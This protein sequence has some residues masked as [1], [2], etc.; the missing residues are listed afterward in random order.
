MVPDTSKA[1]PTAKLR[2]VWRANIQ[3]NK[4][5]KMHDV[6]GIYIIDTNTDGMITGHTISI[7]NGRR[8]VRT[9]TRCTR[10]KVLEHAGQL[11]HD[12]KVYEVTA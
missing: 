10:A 5:N 11:I 6:T 4:A 9:F 12:A 3:K 2:Y 7:K 1:T 8:V